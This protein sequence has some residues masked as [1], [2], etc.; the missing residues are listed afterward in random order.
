VGFQDRR[1]RLEERRATHPHAD[2]HRLQ[3]GN[4]LLNVGPTADGEIPPASV[5]RLAAMGKWMKTNGDSIYGTTASPFA[6]LV[7]RPR[8]A[9]AGKIFLHVFDWPKDG[10]AHH[11]APQRDQEGVPHVRC[12]DGRSRRRSLKSGIVIDVPESA[13]DKIASVIVLEIDGKPDVIAPPAT[14]LRC[15]CGEMSMTQRRCSLLLIVCLRNRS[16]SHVT[17]A[18]V[19]PPP[20]TPTPTPLAS[21]RDPFARDKP[22]RLCIV[23]F[24]A[25][26]RSPEERVEM[27]AR[28]GFKHYA[29]DWRAEHSAHLRPRACRARNSTT[30]S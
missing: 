30:S 2:R 15:Q 7:L 21:S 5:E 11:P 28:L 9:E 20:P 22:R 1:P 18:D 14:K 16:L 26:K 24:D 10:K 13:P 4:Y 8:D 17:R 27:L 25:K 3:G 12:V 6:K 23:P 19:R 29:Y